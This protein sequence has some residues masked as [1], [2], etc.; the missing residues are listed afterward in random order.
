MGKLEEALKRRIQPG[1]LFEPSALVTKGYSLEEVRRD[2]RAATKEGRLNSYSYGLYYLP[3]KDSDIPSSIDAIKLRYI[4]TGDLVYGFFCGSAFIK[5]Y[6]G[7]PLEECQLIEVATNKETSFKK[8]VYRFSRRFI[9]R[10]PYA[11]IDAKNASSLAFLTYL[12]S[13]TDSEVQANLPVLSTYIRDRHLSSEMLV[14]FSQQVPSKAFRRLY[15]SG[16]YRSL[17]KR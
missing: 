15:S 3:G 4:E 10:R 9:L 13:A 17:W 11:T 16:L 8:T 12:C 6:L 2:I 14:K 1:Q 7:Q 5:G